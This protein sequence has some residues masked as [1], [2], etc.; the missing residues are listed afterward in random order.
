MS[1]SVHLGGDW[2]VIVSGLAVICGEMDVSIASCPVNEGN[3]R[4]G[5]R[6]VI[7]CFGL[8]Y[9]ST[10]EVDWRVVVIKEASIRSSNSLNL[11]AEVATWEK[12]IFVKV[13]WC[14]SFVPESIEVLAFW[15]DGFRVNVGKSG[16][17]RSDGVVFVGCLAR[18]LGFRK[19]ILAD[20]P[21]FDGEISGDRDQGALE[22]LVV[23]DVSQE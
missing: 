2:I 16:E 12:T 22:W 19:L 10:L 20:H 5:R 7:D 4:T 23:L 1:Q 18:L 17:L 14:P 3:W 13:I 9:S 21:F 11:L 15:V 6:C 8:R